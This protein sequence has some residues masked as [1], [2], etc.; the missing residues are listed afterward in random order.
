[1]T[2]ARTSAEG[3]RRMRGKCCVT[4]CEAWGAGVWQVGERW[5]VRRSRWAV[6]RSRWRW[7]AHH[8][9][10]QIVL[11]RRHGALRARGLVGGPRHLGG[12][13]LVDLRLGGR[14]ARRLVGRI[15]IRLRDR[16]RLGRLLGRLLGL[17]A[18]GGV[19]GVERRSLEPPLV[20]LLGDAPLLGLPRAP[21]VLLALALGEP[22]EVALP[23]VNVD[24]RGAPA[25]LDG[26]DGVRLVLVAHAPDKHA[27]IVLEHH[28]GHLAR[29]PLLDLGEEQRHDLLQ[30]A[31]GELLH[32]L[33]LAR[34]EEHA[35]A[36]ELEGGAR[37][38]ERERE[39]LIKRKNKR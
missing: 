35:R 16:R 5:A 21:L 2:H 25:V 12:H 13:L 17:F 38:V 24:H 36:A 9:E 37:D 10:D 31:I 3:V 18:R 6:G 39:R 30:V 19:L 7:D 1:M 32:H 29:L 33:P 20:L 15:E 11:L 34:L 28:R 22:H 23:V 4:R 27:A 14:G 8:C 26:A